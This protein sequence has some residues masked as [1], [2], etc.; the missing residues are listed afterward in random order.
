MEYSE[1][2]PCWYFQV[3][4]ALSSFRFWE[5][6]RRKAGYWDTN[7]RL[8]FNQTY[9]KKADI[10]QPFRLTLLY[11]RQLLPKHFTPV[12]EV[13]VITIAIFN[14]DEVPTIERLFK[15]PLIRLS[16]CLIILVFS[17]SNL[18]SDKDNTSKIEI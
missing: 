2:S 10:G 4:I 14:H 3:I 6:F 13:L 7:M 1:A 9:L 17:N 12:K 18:P 8:A 11:V 16:R 5:R 15:S